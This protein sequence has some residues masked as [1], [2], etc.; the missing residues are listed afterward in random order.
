MEEWM[1]YWLQPLTIQLKPS[2]PK[3]LLNGD[4]EVSV[5]NGAGG[6]PK[7]SMVGVP[8]IAGTSNFLGYSYHFLVYHITIA[9]TFFGERI[10]IYIM[11]ISHDFISF[12]WFMFNDM[13]SYNFQWYDFIA[14]SMIS[15]LC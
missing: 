4:M 13:M 2:N 6:C 9:D 10:I 12:Q 1:E 15:P 7:S 3:F 8:P 14:F 11:L 5:Q